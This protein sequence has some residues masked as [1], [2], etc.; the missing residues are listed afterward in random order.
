MKDWV[1][2]VEDSKDCIR[3]NPQFVKGYYRL[4]IAQLELEDYDLAQ[5]TIKQGLALD[6]NNNQLLKVLRTIKQ[7][8]KAATTAVYAPQKKLD[9]A[10]SRELRDLQV[11][12][13]QTSKEYNA[14]QANLGKTQREFK[15]YKVTLDELEANPSTGGY[16]RSI[17]KI[18][19]KSTRDRVLEHLKSTMEGEQKKEIDL[20]QKMEYLERRIKSQEQN[21]QE[22]VSSGE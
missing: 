7:K 11:Q 2:A 13:F 17:G 3:L 14:V 4:A 22:L 15:M 6:A 9:T 16:Y 20:T 1:K 18:F 19:M 12:N 8:K 21:M 10:T 5:A